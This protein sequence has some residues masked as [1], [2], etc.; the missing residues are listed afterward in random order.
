MHTL[1]SALHSK[2]LRDFAASGTAVAFANVATN[3][4]EVSCWPRRL[5]VLQQTAVLL[6]GWMWV[7]FSIYIIQVSVT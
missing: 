1:S 7:G 2:V 3:P 5:V 4:I 6:C